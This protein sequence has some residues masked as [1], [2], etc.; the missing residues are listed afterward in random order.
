MLRGRG[1]AMRILITDGN[2]RAALATARSLVRAGH[3][4][5]VT[6][7]LRHSL[8]GVSRGVRARSLRIDPLTDPAGY[9]AEI[10]RVAR[11]EGTNVLLPMT[12]PSVEALLEHRDALPATVTVPVA[13]LAIYRAASDKAGV[14]ELARSCGF[15]VP[16]TRIIDSPAHCDAELPDTFFPAVVKPHRSVVGA[17]NNRHKLMVTPVADAAEGRAVLAT[18]PPSAF[19]VLLQQ[20]VSGVGEGLFVLRW[21]GRTVALFAH[22]RLREKPPSGGVSVY[23]ESIGLDERF[24][25]PGLRLLDALEWEGVAVIESKREAETGR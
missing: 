9:A 15:A 6:A 7:P 8:A 3:E 21:G 5:C 23:R 19:P 10:G 25:A 13:D 22:R 18:L 24:V 4:V 12:D 2:E 11:Q 1:V 20:R 17:G 14:L 16:D